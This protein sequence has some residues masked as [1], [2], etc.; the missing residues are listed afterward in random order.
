MPVIV[1]EALCA[2]TGEMMENEDRNAPIERLRSAAKSATQF[3]SLRAATES[4]CASV[5]I[6]MI[7]YHHYPPPGADDFRRDFNIYTYGFPPSWVETYRSERL[8]DVDPIPRLASNRTLPFWWFEID[9]LS[10]LN[11]AEAGYLKRLQAAGFGDGLAVPVFGPRGRNGYFGVGF[12]KD[13]SQP[14]DRGVNEIHQACQLVHLRF[15]DLVL[16]RLPNAVTL[17]ERERQILG[18]MLRGHTNQSMAAELGVSA[19]TIETYVRRC[20]EKLDVHDR[21]TAG[22]RGLALGLVS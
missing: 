11:A 2:A 21:V 18:L 13:R 15:C 14:D 16:E 9:K 17:S 7:S 4:Y 22:L 6:E 20:F 1:V 19:N 10:D 3:A 5:G 8:F 12:G